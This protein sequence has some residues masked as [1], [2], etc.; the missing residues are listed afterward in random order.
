MTGRNLLLALILC[1]AVLPGRVGWCDPTQELILSG[2]KAFKAGDYR[3]A[4]AQYSNALTLDP[5]S[6]QSRFNRA[7]AYYRL[8]NLK[9]ALSDFTRVTELDP[10]HNKAQNYCGLIYLKQENY[11][12]A[13]EYFEKAISINPNPIYLLNAALTSF[14]MGEMERARDFS[15]RVLHED[16]GNKWAK[17]IYRK[18]SKLAKATPGSDLAGKSTDDLKLP[19]P[20]QL[21]GEGS[22]KS[23]VGDY[24]RKWAALSNQE[25]KKNA[26]AAAN[27]RQAVDSANLNVLKELL[28]TRIDPDSGGPTGVTALMYSSGRGNLEAVEFL[29]K[30]G[31]NVNL[32]D[33]D[34]N[35]ALMRAAD[36]FPRIVAVL[37]AKGA[38][39]NVKNFRNQTALGLA[40]A[41]CMIET[42]Q[43][44]IEK[45]A[46]PNQTH[47]GF[48]RMSIKSDASQQ[49]LPGKRGGRVEGVEATPLAFAASRGCEA[50]VRLLLAAGAGVNTIDSLGYTPLDHAIETGGETVQSMLRRARGRAN[51]YKTSAAGANRALE[52]KE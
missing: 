35:T 47:V 46:D 27:L 50:G 1:L 32:R 33:A 14:K 8:G 19:E 49:G 43:L 31:A 48:A 9:A 7:L 5:D 21:N 42:M 28:A 4:V 25:K 13:L 36:R 41:R 22:E 11:R 26:E 17:I 20:S 10:Q 38:D 18:V 45:G 3:E 34:G 24:R 44:L 6:K 12:K 51:K 40:S 52:N 15:A 30:S 39:P 2:N 16:P 29:L 23:S 37:L